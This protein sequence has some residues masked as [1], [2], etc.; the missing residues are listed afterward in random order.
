[1][2]LR[3]DN[4]KLAQSEEA[5]QAAEQRAAS[6]AAAAGQLTTAQRDLAGVRAENARLND[7]LQTTERDRGARIA[8]L[9]QENAA[10]GARLRQAQGTLDQIASAARLINGGGSFTTAAP[11]LP[12]SAP[13]VVAA[14]SAPPAPAQPRAHV[15]AEGD[16]LTRISMRYYGTSS[17]WQEI[18]DAN[19]DILKGENTLRP[20][21]RLKIP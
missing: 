17:R 1:M 6:L 7:S 3:T 9:Q 16:S 18:Y 21:Q 8:Q 19:R 2:A 11:G 14:P 10:I 20:G 13:A 5:R 15:V 4:T 12:L